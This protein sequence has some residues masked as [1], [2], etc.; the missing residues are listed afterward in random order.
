L[1]NSP[2][3][4]IFVLTSRIHGMPSPQL[5]VIHPGAVILSTYF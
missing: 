2:T 5:W 3:F 4:L 1:I